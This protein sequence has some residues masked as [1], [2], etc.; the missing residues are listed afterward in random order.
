MSELTRIRV[1]A[2]APETMLLFGGTVVTMDARHT[3]LR[4]AE[5]LIHHGRI[6]A[7]GKSLTAF[8][9][10]RILDCTGCLLIPGL[11]QGHVHLGQ[12][13]FRGLAEGRPLLSWLQERIW[14]LEA[15]HNDESAYWC[16]LLGAAECLLSGT[17]TVQ[18]IGIG[19]G[20]R[21]LL[22]ALLDSRLRSIAGKCLMD[23]G[24]NLPSALREGTEELLNEAEQLGA[25]F[26]QLHQGRMRYAL[27]PRFI[28]SCSDAL[29][30]GIRELAARHNW[31]IHTHG[32]EQLPETELVR[33]LKG[34]RDEIEYF[35]D[36]GILERDLRL[37][38]GVWLGERHLPRLLGRDF[39]VVHC[40][41]SN[42]KL[43]S[44]IADVVGLRRAGLKVGL[45]CDGA[46]CNNGLDAFGEVRLAALLQTVKHGPSAFSAREALSLATRE[47]AR[48]LGLERET[49]SLEAGKKA[50]LVVLGTDSAAAQAASSVDPHD[51]VCFSANASWV[52][53]VFV[54][55]EQ[56]VVDG[57]LAHL[58]LETIRSEADR[59]R[60]ALLRRS[61]LGLI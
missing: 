16:T 61:G 32:L 37:A 4:D 42:L 17:T 50:D 25:E 35:D 7:I 6:A 49:G 24:E 34:G 12:T 52:R 1:D 57:R 58:D 22:L 38:H 47:G 2:P 59:T 23:E 20:V 39:S 51:L 9:R 41:G 15:A 27:N 46:A 13:F 14:P 11:I 44:G 33:S 55:G 21:G 48:A 10:T 18:D 26:D 54:E 45:G 53:H 60:K 31:P 28:L 8:P 5:I 40:P 3:V 43:G 56:L 36:C 30:Q 19:P 29:W